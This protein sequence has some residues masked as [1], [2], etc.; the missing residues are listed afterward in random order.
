[1]LNIPTHLVF[2]KM[3]ITFI[4]RIKINYRVMQPKPS[5]KKPEYFIKLI[6][7]W[8]LSSGYYSLITLSVLFIHVQL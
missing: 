1:M 3:L 6:S 5:D 2:T 8:V 7:C 4:K